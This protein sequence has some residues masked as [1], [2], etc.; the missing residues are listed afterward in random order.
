MEKQKYANTVFNHFF[1]AQGFPDGSAG[2]EFACSSGDIGGSGLIPG[3][4]RFTL[5]EDRTTHSSVLAGK[6]PWTEEPG[7]L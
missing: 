1:L 3:L 4:G 7:G 2:N 6:I 5:E